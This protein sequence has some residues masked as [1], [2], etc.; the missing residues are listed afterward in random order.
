MKRK[1][2]IIKEKHNDGIELVSSRDLAYIGD[3]AY[4]VIECYIKLML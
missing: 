3:I 1:K 4:S 2:S